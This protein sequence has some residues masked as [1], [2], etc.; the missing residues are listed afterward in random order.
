MIIHGHSLMIRCLM[1]HRFCI[2]LIQRLLLQK[3]APGHQP[4]AVT[5]VSEF[6]L[7]LLLLSSYM[8]KRQ[9]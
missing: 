4:W 5:S 2:H 9:A 6:V 1:L 3:P 8:Q 7:E